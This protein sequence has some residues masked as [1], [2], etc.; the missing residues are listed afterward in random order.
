MDLQSEQEELLGRDKRPA[1]RAQEV[2]QVAL[3][4]EEKHVRTDG[5]GL[6][7]GFASAGLQHPVSVQLSPPNGDFVP[8]SEW[9]WVLLARTGQVLSPCS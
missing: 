7:R 4:E 8:K 6:P 9:R 1:P 5:M 2:D 3:I